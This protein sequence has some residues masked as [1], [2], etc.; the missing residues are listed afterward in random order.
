MSPQRDE[1]AISDKGGTPNFGLN[2]NIVASRTYLSEAHLRRFLAKMI[3]NCDPLGAG[4]F[5]RV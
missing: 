5:S 2:W 3:V 1:A 4:H